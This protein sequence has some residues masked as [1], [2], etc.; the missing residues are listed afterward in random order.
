MS[1]RSGKSDGTKGSI[2]KPTGV[3]DTKSKSGVGVTWSGRTQVWGG[4]SDR[5][6]LG[7]EEGSD[8]GDS[9]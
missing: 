8:F 4:E 9:S 1:N 5:G 7:V 6:T 2:L 3:T